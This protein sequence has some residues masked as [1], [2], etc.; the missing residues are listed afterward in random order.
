MSTNSE[1]FLNAF[2]SIDRHLRRLARIDRSTSFAGAVDEAARSDAAAR[3]YS[4]DLKEY[5]DLRNA[6]VHERTDAHP[7]AEP[8]PETVTAIEAILEKLTRPPTVGAEF[9]CEV[10]QVGLADRV[11]AA[12]AVMREHRFSQLPVYEGNAFQGLLTAATMA[13]W[14]AERLDGELGML[15]EESVEVVLSF[16]EDAE[17]HVRF[18]SR[19]CSVFDAIEAFETHQRQ[20]WALDALVVTHSGSPDQTPLGIITTFD[21]G[22]LYELAS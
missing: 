11:G 10:A 19:V 3:R 20:G 8:F 16:T 7:I 12:A 6:I 5:A 2:N 18:I 13:W 1:R 21:L 17:H 15:D 14:L 4:I 9:A 22:R